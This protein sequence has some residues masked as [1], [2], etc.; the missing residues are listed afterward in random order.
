MPALVGRSADYSSRRRT[1]YGS[2]G[3]VATSDPL[4]A[5]AAMDILRRGG[6]A[7]DAAIAA[8]AVLTVVDPTSS[9]LGSDAMA[10]VWH[11]DKVL[12]LDGS[13]RALQ[14][15]T[16]E[17]FR[18]QGLERIPTCGWPAVTVPGMPA[19]WR[20]LHRK[21]G[22]LPFATLFESAIFHATYGFPVGE[23]TAATWSAAARRFREGPTPP[24]V[25]HW[26]STFLDDSRPPQPGELWTLPD[27]AWTLKILAESQC[28]AFYAGPIAD[29]MTSFASESGG[30]LT[31]GDLVA[32]VTQWVEPLTV[33]YRGCDVWQLPPMG[34]GIGVLSALNILSLSDIATREREDAVSYHL[35]IEAT[36][37]ALAD[38]IGRVTRRDVGDLTVQTLLSTPHARRRY[39][40]IAEHA[41][42]PVPSEAPG[43]GTAALCVSDADGMMIS[44]LQSNYSGFMLGFGSGVVI[45]GTGV[46][47]QSR[48]T[49]FSL[50]PEAPHA[51]APSAKPIHT[52]A[53]GFISR[54]GVPRCALAFTG[55]PMQPQ[56]LIQAVVGLLDHHLSPQSILDA[57]RWQWVEERAV[58]LEPGLDSAVVDELVRRKHEVTVVR[59]AEVPTVRQ[60]RGGLVASGDF[61]K[62]QLIER[63]EN[64]V[65]A[66]GT[67]PRAAG[68]AI[69]F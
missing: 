64:G 2:R 16:L 57:P 69:G 43:A 9:G 37:L 5:E 66:A 6:S 8:S 63:L 30:G 23:L 58:E 55:G 48:G 26:G 68:V 40:R 35:Q 11:K 52:L 22:R 24:E 33:R 62:G 67:D 50:D 31:R 41:L 10:L 59:A 51:L 53:P 7:A 42:R 28:E 32:H 38:T 17:S 27:H 25:Q 21:L 34:P 19:A 4:A 15:H 1:V 47:L 29:R 36:K 49:S 56:A 44:W 3:M 12:G 39:E 13:G 46:A 45:P 60:A 20:D 54:A 18:S 14:A 61:G 65:Y